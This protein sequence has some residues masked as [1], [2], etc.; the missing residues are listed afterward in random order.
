ME[1]ACLAN[2]QTCRLT[3][4]TRAISSTALRSL[5]TFSLLKQTTNLAVTR[6]ETHLQAEAAAKPAD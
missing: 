2:A 5:Q 6:Q 4:L 1:T 3:M